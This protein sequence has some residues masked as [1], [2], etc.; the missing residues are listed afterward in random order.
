MCLVFFLKVTEFYLQ[1]AATKPT[2]VV[3]VSRRL[4]LGV[5]YLSSM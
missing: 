1:I 5:P 3:T 4:F 2:K